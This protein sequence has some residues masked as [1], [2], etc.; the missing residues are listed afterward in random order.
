MEAFLEAV[1][2]SYSAPQAVTAV[3][4][5][6]LLNVAQTFD[7]QT[8]GVY[9]E[10]MGPSWDTKS[11]VGQAWM[12]LALVQN[13]AVRGVRYNVPG[14]DVCCLHA[15]E[16]GFS[17]AQDVLYECM[18]DMSVCGMCLFCG[19]CREEDE[20]DQR[21]VVLQNGLR[22]CIVVL[23][24]AVRTCIAPEV[25]LVKCRRQLESLL[26]TGDF[27]EAADLLHELNCDAVP[28][29]WEPTTHMEFPKHVRDSIW[30]WL[31]VANR[32]GFRKDLRFKVCRFIA[33]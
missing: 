26:A 31:L 25:N 5:E 13:L 6:H 1:T 8:L 29:R 30:T 32:I 33:E 17:E 24:N 2:L 11:V 20:L 9:A 21:D 16:N 28:E 23:Q 4:A 14:V 10:Y 22:T 18:K 3:Q 27:F 7:Q 15:L 19:I 12:S